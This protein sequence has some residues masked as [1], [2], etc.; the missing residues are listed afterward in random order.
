MFQNIAIC[1]NAFR[2]SLSAYEA[3]KA[4]DEGLSLSALNCNTYLLPVAD[5][6]DGTLAVW[7][8]AHNA[9]VI[10]CQ[11]EGPRGETIIAEYGLAGP[12]AMIEMARASGIELL[13]K[14]ERNPL[15]TST[16]GTGQLIRDAIHKGARHILVGVGGSATVDGGAGALF[17]LGARFKDATGDDVIP[18]GGNLSQIVTV[19]LDE[20]NALLADVRIDVLCDVENPLLGVEGAAPVFAPQKGA[21]AAMVVQLS[22]N[23]AYFAD[24]IEEA[25]GRHIHGM[26]RGGAAGGLCAGLIGLANASAQSGA[27]YLIDACGYN[28]IFEE[29][30]IDL[31][32]AGEGKLDSQTVSGKA[33]Q[34]VAQTAAQFN[35]PTIAV[36]GAL[37]LKSEEYARL[38]L[39]AVFSIVQHP[40]SLADALNNAEVWLRMTATNIGNLL[41]VKDH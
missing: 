8:H 2:G 29:E 35:I 41:S 38:S 39:N 14:N 36:V 1:P 32:I 5:G 30:G 21:D 19:D 37:N 6:G 4:I 12:V 22:D 9:D 24:R 26:P 25:T 10:Q 13:K 28:V 23:L 27:S 18:N 31:V 17:A 7:Q 34:I 11:V 33:L 20:S 15:L 16:V 40:C 3:A